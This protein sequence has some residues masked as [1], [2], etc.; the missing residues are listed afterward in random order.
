[1]AAVG[2][3]HVNVV[4]KVYSGKE[5]DA[6]VAQAKGYKRIVWEILNGKAD[7]DP[8]AFLTHCKHVCQEQSEKGA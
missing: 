1:M 7:E 3:A 4:A 6:I 2:T 8:R 5:A